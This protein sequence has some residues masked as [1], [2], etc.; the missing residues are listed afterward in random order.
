MSEQPVSAEPRIS[1]EAIRKMD[2]VGRRFR[3]QLR[4][5]AVQLSQADGSGV[6]ISPETISKALP[7]VCRELLSAAGSDREDE[8]GSDD[9]RSEAA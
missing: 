1:L 9:R 8:R 3:R 4:D 7:L 6:L 2:D 5:C